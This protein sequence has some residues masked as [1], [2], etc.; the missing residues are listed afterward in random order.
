MGKLQY[1]I[2]KVGTRCQGCFNRLFPS[3]FRGSLI[4]PER[5]CA[6]NEMCKRSGY[7][8]QVQC[9]FQKILQTSRRILDTWL[10]GFFTEPRAKV[11]DEPILT[12]PHL[13]IPIKLDLRRG[14]NSAL[15]QLSNRLNDIL[16]QQPEQ[17]FVIRAVASDAQIELVRMDK[18]LCGLIPLDLSNQDSTGLDLLIRLV[19]SSYEENGYY[20]PPNDISRQIISAGINFQF[21]TLMVRCNDQTFWWAV[22]KSP[23]GMPLYFV[24]APREIV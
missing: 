17:T 20:C 8:K 10:S 4:R 19:T 18:L 5:Q 2:N 14:H 23:E 16:E 3:T 15:R 9:F 13:I 24:W 7:P 11:V 12:W 21:K 22:F 1:S 6:T